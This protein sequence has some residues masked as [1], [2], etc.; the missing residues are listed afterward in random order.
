M[1]KT[2][3]QT[4]RK[5]TTKV[6]EKGGKVVKRI[7]NIVETQVRVRKENGLN[8]EIAFEDTDRPRKLDRNDPDVT[9]INLD[10]NPS[11]ADLAEAADVDSQ[12][13][14]DKLADA[15]KQAINDISDNLASVADSLKKLA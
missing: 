12:D 3:V 13:D 4:H 11:A 10:D 1:A 9:F 5:I 14:A 15:R 2:V 6:F 8:Q 7:R